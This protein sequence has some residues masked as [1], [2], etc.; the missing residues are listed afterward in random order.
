MTPTTRTSAIAGTVAAV[1]L[2][3]AVIAR[4][5]TQ[6]PSVPNALPAAPAQHSEAAAPAPA[7]VAATVTA[8]PTQETAAAPSGRV[9]PSR[10]PLCDDDD[11][12][13][14]ARYSL[15]PGYA[16]LASRCD[17]IHAWKADPNGGDVIIWLG[18]HGYDSPAAD[19][20]YPVEVTWRA[21]EPRWPLLFLT[22]HGKQYEQPMDVT[23]EAPQVI[24]F[25]VPC[26]ADRATGGDGVFTPGSRT[27]ICVRVDADPLKSR[28][29]DLPADGKCGEPPPL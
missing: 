27:K 10:P 26:Y 3:A 28:T 20:D 1:A 18:D 14:A 2:V 5:G 12:A 25:R 6:T 24:T 11:Q 22:Y 29:W 13:R 7:P 15:T 23:A 19:C 16:Y 8:A 21:G 4:Y 9:R 17:I